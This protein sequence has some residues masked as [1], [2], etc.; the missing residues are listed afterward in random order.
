[1]IL[2]VNY[3][4]YNRDLLSGFVPLCKSS[5]ISENVGCVTLNTRERFWKSC[6]CF[7]PGLKAQLNLIL[8]SSLWAHLSRVLCHSLELTFLQNLID[9]FELFGGCRYSSGAIKINEI[10]H[11]L[12]TGW[13]GRH[14]DVSVLIC[15]CSQTWDPSFH[16]KDLN[17]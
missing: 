1:M 16:G 5:Y 8:K 13:H 3:C 15:W 7:E 12:L 11:D 4:S 9:K 2:L 6:K 17:C 10:S 14:A